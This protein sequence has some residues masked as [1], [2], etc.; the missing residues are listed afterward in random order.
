MQSLLWEMLCCGSPPHLLCTMSLQTSSAQERIYRNNRYFHSLSS[1]QKMTTWMSRSLKENENLICISVPLDFWRG[2]HKKD[3][4]IPKR[5]REHFAW[6]AW[7]FHTQ[8]LF[9]GLTSVRQLCHI[10]NK[11]SWVSEINPYLSYLSFSIFT[12]YPMTCPW[13]FASK[14]LK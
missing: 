6:F 5:E 13:L 12:C 3:W 8:I 1:L 9:K 7:G 2:Q 10:L 11:L 14:S 4:I